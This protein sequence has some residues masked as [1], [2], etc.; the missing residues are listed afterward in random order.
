MTSSTGISMPGGAIAQ[1]LGESVDALAAR[2]AK[3]VAGRA[4]RPRRRRVQRDLERAAREEAEGDGCRHALVGVDGEHGAVRPVGDVGDG[5]E[6]VRCPA[7]LVE[8]AAAVR[9]RSERGTRRPVPQLEAVAVEADGRGDGARLDAECPA[10]LLDGHVGGLDGTRGRGDQDERDAERGKAH[11][12]SRYH[13]GRAA[14][15]IAS[16]VL[17]PI[18]NAHARG[19]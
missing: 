1:A 19:A 2:R 9:L 10:A 11:G 4:D 12:V 13:S 5:A 18:A 16:A 17:D 15:Q 6:P 7:A 14:S 3:A 8:E